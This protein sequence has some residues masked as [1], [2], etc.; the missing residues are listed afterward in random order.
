MQRLARGLIVDCVTYKRNSIGVPEFDITL[1]NRLYPGAIVVAVEGMAILH[2]PPRSLPWGAGEFKCDIA[3]GLEVDEGRTFSLNHFADDWID[4]VPRGQTDVVAAA[5]ITKFVLSDGLAIDVH[6]LSTELEKLVAEYKELRDRLVKVDPV[7]QS[8]D[9]IAWSECPETLPETWTVRGKD[10]RACL[11]AGARRPSE[12]STDRRPDV[13]RGCVGSLR[14]RSRRDQEGDYGRSLD[15]GARV[16]A[17]DVDNEG[18]GGCGPSYC[19]S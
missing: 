16:V 11:V 17:I 6:E 9:A 13:R 4:N 10:I 5:K 14:C 15:G 12:V 19:G 2:S 3:G 18:Q 1:E 7:R 8:V